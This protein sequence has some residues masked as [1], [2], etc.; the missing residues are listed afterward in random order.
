MANLP[1]PISFGA[2]PKSAPAAP[3]P[4]ALPNLGA[5]PSSISFGVSATTPATKPAA[6]PVP[7]LHA[8]DNSLIGKYQN[9]V[10]AFNSNILDI[11]KDIGLGIKSIKDFGQAVA[12]TSESIFQSGLGLIAPGAFPDTVNVP[13]FLQ[14]VFGAEKIDNAGK[15]VLA[16]EASIKSSPT[17]QSMGLD[18]HATAF[19]FA[20]VLGDEI[21]NTLG[22]GFGED[23]SLIKGIAAEK[24]AATIAST[25]RTHGVS[26]QLADHF[27]PHLA[28]TS[29]L[30]D[31]KGILD[32]IKGMQGLEDIHALTAPKPDAL[33]VPDMNTDWE[34]NFAPKY[35]ELGQQVSELDARAKTAPAAERASLQE[36][37]HSLSQEQAKIEQ[38]FLKK[39]GGEPM[40]GDTHAAPLEAMQSTPTKSLFDTSAPPTEPAAL[41]P[42]TA[43]VT[44]K[45]FQEMLNAADRDRGNAPGA[46]V[47]GH[48]NNQFHQ[49]KRLYGDYLRAQDPGMFDANYSEYLNGSR[50]EL[51]KYRPTDINAAVKEPVIS[52]PVENAPTTETIPVATPITEVPKPTQPTPDFTYTPVG[53]DESLALTEKQNQEWQYATH[54]NP[55][56]KL[57]EDLT[58]IF[59]DLNKV[60][61][62]DLKTPFTP[63]D[64]QTAKT[65]Y[66]IG[67]EA[68]I[69][70][71][72]RALMKY[73]SRQSGE[74]PEVG[75]SRKFAN[76]TEAKAAYE[77]SY[78]T[79]L[80][81]AL[82]KGLDNAKAVKYAENYAAQRAYGG[83]F[84]R[85]GDTLVQD[86]LGQETSG[87]GDVMRAQ[88]LVDDY[89]ALKARVD[90]VGEN[91]KNIRKTI[92][93]QKQAGTF[94]ESS[95]RA[96]ARETVKDVEAMKNLVAAAKRAGVSEGA[97]QGESIVERMT[98]ELKTRRLKITEIQKKFELTDTQLKRIM[99]RRDPRFM[100]ADEFATYTD[101]LKEQAAALRGSLNRYGT[102]VT[103]GQELIDAVPK[104][105]EGSWQSMVKGY[106]RKLDPKAKA[107]ALDYLGT[108]EFV[109]ERLGLNKA[110]E[111]LHDAQDAYLTT[112]D[113][114]L[115]KIADWK[116]QAG[117]RPY[118]STRIFRY[119]DGREREVVPEMSPNELQVARE[120]RASLK[121]W[122]ERLHLPEDNR[123]A[124]YITHLFEPGGEIPES[125]FLK[126]PE[127][128]A[129]MQEK[130]AGSVYDPFLQQ[131][132]GKKGYIE[133]AFR[134]LDAYV[135]R[136]SRKEAFD[137]I[138]DQ[139]RE[140][141]KGLDQKT[142]DYLA[143]LTH[144]INMRPTK[145]DSLIDSFVT[146]RL[147]ITRFT[148]RPVA[149]I[150]KTLRV[151]YYR[152]LLGLNV[153]SAL[154]NLSQG[155]NTYA[156]LGEK[157][158]M[159]GYAK[160]MQ[161]LAARDLSEL[162]E[163]HVLDEAMI[164]DRKV[165]IYKTALQK[166]DPVLFAMFDTAEKINR[167]AAYF[168]AKSQALAKGLDEE[169]A[170]KYA[171][172]IVRET[173]FAFSS[174]DAPVA[175]SSDIAKVFTQLQTYNIKQIELLGRMA[176]NKEYA[177]L[178]RYTMASLGF[179]YTVGQLFGMTA[180]QIVPAVRFASAPLTTTLGNIYN[181][182][183][184]STQQ[185]KTKA[186][187]Q[188]VKTTLI[189]HIPGGNQIFNKTIP[190]IE[191]FNKGKDT[192]PTGKTRFTIPKTN[193][194]LMKIILFGKSSIPEAQQ[195]YQGI[196]KK[197]PT[198]AFPA[199]L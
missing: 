13:K 183:F 72:G 59:A 12:R 146:D 83:K 9:F 132:L 165:G 29:N 4:S 134:A 164:Q 151:S 105:D 142:Y 140:Q 123:I 52:T 152:A 42:T 17:A 46:V 36:Q 3:P 91:L 168:G 167:G 106:F 122:A 161:K 18:K 180:N 15:Q 96:L 51:D 56:D 38:E 170:I 127:L 6:P 156:K 88:E 24:D 11:P 16:L 109:L 177:G 5:L 107:D 188:L 155:A 76:S 126:D 67:Q 113:A 136:A 130:V 110:A 198:S 169:Q 44:K 197:K 58:S 33:A 138:L 112:R 61:V 199:P 41:P 121:D 162:Y 90:K 175:L 131:R 21:L 141:S 14:P 27:A 70:H 99:G 95:K 179:V 153:S 144:R 84:A 63:E 50:P 139:I 135:K 20:G 120:M 40:Q 108:P 19:A 48:R 55:A 147:G 81:T 196:G 119:L 193:E 73:V 172:R 54:G 89:K 10:S 163:V 57:T 184:G 23:A 194:N 85:E 62:G 30:K 149:Y 158:T 148:E 174:V 8:P 93:L 187:G 66:E 39:Y 60:K 79:G 191:A 115:A 182:A 2:A 176:K 186:R 26:P 129:I 166:F 75:R 53:E 160:I 195:Y 100:T 71:P 150:S 31:V 64:L 47:S 86:L 65:Q 82:R 128:S 111:M 124:R 22:I 117:D 97:Q 181:S 133:D 78:N 80:N 35:G 104:A 178:L 173:Q 68:L 159:I 145:L 28:D 98:Q 101:K 192:T 74:L 25:L 103:P 77:E 190:G 43:Q 171:K 137:P 114:E 32:T 189:S 87:G 69:D 143:T 102:A 185:D 154:R 1:P 49:A 157:Y 45:Q 116:A 37:S 94:V 125:E 7:T 92:T 34:T 118:A